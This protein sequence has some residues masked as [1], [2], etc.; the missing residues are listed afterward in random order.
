MGY[1]DDDGNYVC[2]CGEPGIPMSDHYGIYMGIFCCD[3]CV[4][5]AGY[6][7]NWEF[8]PGYAGES[9]YGDGDDGF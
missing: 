2:A 4:A 5:K 7:P 3:E 8:D 9:L 6:N 1:R